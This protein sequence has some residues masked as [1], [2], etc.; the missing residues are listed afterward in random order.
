MKLTLTPQHGLPG[1]PGMSIHV[2][3][4]VIT[5]DGLPY[6][7]GAVPE[8]G[9]GWPDEGPFIGPITRTGGVLNVA[10]IAR[11]GDDAAADQGGPWVIDAEG[12]VEITYARKEAEE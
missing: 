2:A 8:G 1:Q 7:L 12:D 9:E 4:D 3:G 5:I 6:D 11:L 10:L